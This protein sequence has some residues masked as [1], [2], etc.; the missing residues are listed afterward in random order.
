MF[1]HYLII[2][3]IKFNTELI[4]WK[5]IIKRILN[6]NLKRN[7]IYESTIKYI[8]KVKYNY[9]FIIYCFQINKL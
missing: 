3:Y 1:I 2:I 5:Y 6:N 7:P 8:F 9:I 4:I